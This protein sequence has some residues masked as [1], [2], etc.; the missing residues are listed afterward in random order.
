MTVARETII[1]AL[2]DIEILEEST[3]QNLGALVRECELKG[4][5][6]FLE[7]ALPLLRELQTDSEEHRELVKRILERLSDGTDG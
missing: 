2:K 4:N 6:R 1:Q 3:L 5:P 7:Q